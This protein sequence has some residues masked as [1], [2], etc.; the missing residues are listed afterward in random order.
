MLGCMLISSCLEDLH[1]TNIFKFNFYRQPELHET[2]GFL[3]GN[4][5]I[6]GLFWMCTAFSRVFVIFIAR[7]CA[8]EAEHSDHYTDAIPQ[9]IFI[10]LLFSNNWPAGLMRGMLLLCQIRFFERVKLERQIKQL[11]KPSSDET[12]EAEL[13]KKQQDI[14]KLRDDLQVCYTAFLYRPKTLDR[15]HI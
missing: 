7:C 2:L 5:V 3:N 13:E 15:R 11:E 6:S 8:D 1:G 12:T 10:H 4:Q 9:M 14:L